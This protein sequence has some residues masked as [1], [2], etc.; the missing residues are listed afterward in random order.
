MALNGALQQALSRN[1]ALEKQQLWAQKRRED[2]G[3]PNFLTLRSRDGDVVRTVAKV[4]ADAEVTTNEVNIFE[5]ER[6]KHAAAKEDTTLSRLCSGQDESWK[7]DSFFSESL[8]DKDLPWSVR[9]SELLGNPA[10]VQR[11]V[12]A[13]VASRK[14]HKREKK[15]RK[16]GKK[17]KKKEKKK[18]ER[19]TMKKMKK[20]RDSKQKKG[21]DEQTRNL[22]SSGSDAEAVQDTTSEESCLKD[23]EISHRCDMGKQR[24]L[25]KDLRI[26]RDLLVEISSRESGPSSSDSE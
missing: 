10:M 21:N 19:K 16:K 24:H 12:D 9:P 20:D 14:R 1:K 26:R 4:P 7:P 22:R 11:I 8:G 6:R 25:D 18:K 3:A 2:H 17:Q 13:Y 23:C 15:E 5:A